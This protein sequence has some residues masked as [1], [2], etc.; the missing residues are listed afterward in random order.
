MLLHL[1]YVIAFTTL[2]FLA[3]GNLIR[4]LMTL[5]MES[6]RSNAPKSWAM[7]EPQ[8]T[9][10]SRLRMVPHPEFLDTAGNVIN[11]PLLVMRSMSVEDAREQLDA[12]YESSP[13]ANSSGS[14]DRHE[15][16]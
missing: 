11:E 16:A 10:A 12:L 9:G 6:Q 1:L 2:A 3:V 7:G 13:G 14:G 5:G 15:D 4:N 8:A